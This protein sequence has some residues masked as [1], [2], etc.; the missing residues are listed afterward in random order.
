M[1]RKLGVTKEPRR[2]SDVVV[3]VPPSVLKTPLRANVRDIFKSVLKAVATGVGGNWAASASAAAEIP[4][5]A[6]V[7][8][9]AGG[10]AWLLIRAALAAAL[11]DLVTER[12]EGVD[13]DQLRF[14]E[15][16]DRLELYLEE[17]EWV[18]TSEM[19]AQPRS[20]PVVVEVQSIAED[21]LVAAGMP[22]SDA[23]AL[24]ERLPSY[25]VAALEAEWQAHAERFSILAAALQ[26][27]FNRA[28]REERSWLRHHAL[29]ERQVD[30]PVFDAAFGLRQIYIP[31]R[32]ARMKT[33]NPRKNVK[34]VILDLADDLRSWIRRTPPGDT[35]RA[36]SGGP[37]SGKSSVLRMFASQLVRDGVCRVC[38]LPLYRL[39]PFVSFEADLEDLARRD[40]A[41]PANVLGG[42]G[43]PRTVLLLDGLD[44]IPLDGQTLEQ[45]SSLFLERTI[46]LIDRIN[47][48]L[49]VARVL[50]IVAGRELVMQQQRRLLPS[51]RIYEIVPFYMPESD[52]TD[53]EDPKGLLQTD[54]RDEWWRRYGSLTAPITGPCQPSSHDPSLSSLPANRSSTTWSLSA[55]NASASNSRR[56]PL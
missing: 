18:L 31:P 41:F 44:E 23:M 29:L 13:L 37:G 9:N 17:T 52:R 3:R 19:L 48:G 27:P 30:Q 28:D 46:R 32:A 33:A 35:V 34:P 53:V 24:K 20:F 43:G 47:N 5:A 55:T 49:A 39:N 16:A 26:S 7:K 50:A 22:R 25:F 14:F 36:I 6:S 51:N 10:L 8:R 38:Y 40:P 42:P 4:F 21:W 54:Q 56:R 12:P 11:A 1:T 45:V 2:R 15:L